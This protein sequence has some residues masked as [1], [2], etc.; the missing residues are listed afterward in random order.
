MKKKQQNKI[1]KAWVLVSKTGII[2]I[3]YRELGIYLTEHAA[4]E[5]MNGK[6]KYIVP[7]EIHYNPN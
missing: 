1:V 4:A 3:P 6:F 5:N 7:C 2:D